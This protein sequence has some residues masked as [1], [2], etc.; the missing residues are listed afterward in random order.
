MLSLKDS[1]EKLP[2]IQTRFLSKIKKLGIETVQDLLYHFPT[3]YEDFSQIYPI[4]DL[5]PSQ[6]ATVQGVIEEVKSRRS[7]QRH[8]TI[9]EAVISD[10]TASIRAVWFNQPYIRSALVPGRLASFSGR[11]REKDG[12]LSLS[13][14]TYEIVGSRGETN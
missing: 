10:D 11:V 4:A 9:V 1:I 2:R 12:V 5:I 14:P 6:E 13:N 8:I 7:W 3:R